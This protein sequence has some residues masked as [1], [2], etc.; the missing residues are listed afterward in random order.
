LKIADFW[1]NFRFLGKGV[2]KT[3]SW[4]DYVVRVYL[5]IYLIF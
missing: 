2:D 4:E 5:C 3:A 1:K